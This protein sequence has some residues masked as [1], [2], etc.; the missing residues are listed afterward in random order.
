V[1]GR[2]NPVMTG[3]GPVIHVFAWVNKEDVDGRAGARP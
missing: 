3:L 1:I 2:A